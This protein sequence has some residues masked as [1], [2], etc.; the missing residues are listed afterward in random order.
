[1]LTL[2]FGLSPSLTSRPTASVANLNQLHITVTLYA[3]GTAVEIP[4]F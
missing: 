1:M 2:F 3:D 4:I